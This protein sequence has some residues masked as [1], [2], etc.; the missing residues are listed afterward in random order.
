MKGPSC[1]ECEEIE[2]ARDSDSDSRRD[3]GDG[4]SD[5]GDGDRWKLRARGRRSSKK[6]RIG[7]VGQPKGRREGWIEATK[8]GTK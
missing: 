3:V 5:V 7:Q 4:D 1:R 6:E 8:S 2:V